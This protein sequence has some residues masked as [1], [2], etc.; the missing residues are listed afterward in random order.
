MQPQ[1][2]T[3]RDPEAFRLL[4][5]RYS[6]ILVAEGRCVQHDFDL[7]GGAIAVSIAGIADNERGHIVVFPGETLIE[8]ATEDA[9]LA[10]APHAIKY[11]RTGSGEENYTIPGLAAGLYTVYAAAHP[12]PREDSE[13]IL[14]QIR[15]IYSVTEVANE[16]TAE[17]HFNFTAPEPTETSATSDN[18]GEAQ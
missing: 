4:V 3:E 10:L 8:E 17:I 1:W 9:L 14:A 6:A 18:G 2:L 12:K 15:I 16:D 13:D 5:V 11:I 7:G